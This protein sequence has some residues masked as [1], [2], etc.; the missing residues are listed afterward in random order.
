MGLNLCACL[1]ILEPAPVYSNQTFYSSDSTP[2]RAVAK[3][4]GSRYRKAIR[5]QTPVAILIR[6]IL[7]SKRQCCAAAV[8]NRVEGRL[9]SL[10]VSCK[11]PTSSQ[12]WDDEN[13]SEVDF[14]TTPYGRAWQRVRNRRYDTAYETCRLDAGP[15]RHVWAW[16]E[17][18][19]RMMRTWWK[20]TRRWNGRWCWSTRPFWV[21]LTSLVT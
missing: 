19:F 5:V 16:T 7:F 14:G 3:E 18:F 4:N 15:R 13:M 8:T 9:R 11:Q 21:C 20:E 17:Q 1:R 12:R 2:D 10:C 6:W